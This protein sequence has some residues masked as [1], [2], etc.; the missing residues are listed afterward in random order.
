VD[1]SIRAL[2]VES[3]GL[4]LVVD[5]RVGNVTLGRAIGMSRTDRRGARRRRQNQVGATGLI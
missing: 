1:R 4:R 5:T 3:K 2:V